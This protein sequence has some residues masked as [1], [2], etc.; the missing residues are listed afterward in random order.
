MIKHNFYA[1]KTNL[2]ADSINVSQESFTLDYPDDSYDYFDVE[3]MPLYLRWKTIIQNMGYGTDWVS[4]SVSDHTGKIEDAYV[5]SLSANT[6]SHPR[7]ANVRFYDV[8]G[9]APDVNVV[10]TQMQEPA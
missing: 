3:V 4:I 2:V 8:A 9:R 10:V 6:G 7:S 1:K 5:K